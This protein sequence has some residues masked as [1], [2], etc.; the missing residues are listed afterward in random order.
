[1]PRI[2]FLKDVLP[3]GTR[4]S[5]RYIKK[6]VTPEGKKREIVINEMYDAIDDALE[7]DI[8]RHV[9]E[10]RDVY[11]ATAG[12]GKSPKANGDNA[13]AKKEI[14]ID[15]DCGEEKPYATK[16]EGMVALR[17]FVVNVGLPKPTILD[18]G[19]GIHAHWY[20]EAAIPVHEWKSMAERLKTLCIDKNFQVDG[21]C[22]AD[23]VRVL[24]IP[25]T[26]NFRGNHTTKLLTPVK[27]HD[28]SKLAH[29]LGLVKTEN[30]IDFAAARALSQGQP[31]QGMSEIQKLINS[32]RTSKFQTIVNRS[33]ADGTGCAQ[34]KNAI[35]NA[36]SLPEPLWRGVLSIAQYCEDRDWG[37]HHASDAHPNYTPEETEAKAA[38]TK[39]PYT[40]E[41]FQKLDC[42]QLCSG[43][44]HAGKITSPIQLGN[45]VIVAKPEDNKVVA[46]GVEYEIPSYPHPY[47][48]AKSGGIW[49][50]IKDKETGIASQEVIYPYD[51][52]IFK[53]MRDAEHGECNFVRLHLP[54]GDTRE[55]MITQ[56]ELSAV[57]KMRDTISAMG[58]ASFSANTLRYIQEFFALLIVDI[59]QR[60]VPDK[61]KTRM[62]WTTDDTFVVGNREY[63]PQGMQTVPVAKHLEHYAK[64]F[65][66]VG[67]LAEWKKIAAQYKGPESYDYALALLGG[68]ASPLMHFTNENGGIINL[69]S[70]DSGSGKTTTQLVINSIF[71]HPLNL[72]KTEQDTAL[73]KTN[74]MG[75]HNGIPLCFDEMTN[76]K[77]E[78]I[79][80]LVYNSTQGRA[81]DRM[82]ANANAER[83]NDITWKMLTTWSSNTSIEDRLS[84][85]KY[86]PAGELARVIELR[87]AEVSESSNVLAAQQQFGK[88]YDH[89]GVAGH[90]FM[91]Y[92]VPNADV[93]KKIIEDTRADMYSKFA[94]RQADRFRVNILTVIISAGIITNHIGLTDYD[95]AGLQAHA[96]RMITNASLE[97]MQN[98]TKAIETI[99]MY[100]NKNINN[101]LSVKGNVR[102]GG[103]LEQPAREPRGALMVRY[104]TDTKELYI[105]QREFNKWCASVFINSREIPAMFKKE[106]GKDM[107]LVKKRMGKGWDA[108][109]GP[110]LAYKIDDASTT[111]GF[112]DLDTP[113]N[114]PPAATA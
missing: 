44:P 41:S 54:L 96:I 5:M 34:I 27:Y 90:E 73:S 4:Y 87:L 60:E 114:V 7:A 86:N 85:I 46:G 17:D 75:V 101:I 70:K 104:E 72:M 50:Y 108:D 3:D 97:A 103:L 37:I 68:F 113:K 58:V 42:P 100:I 93:V 2:D 105:P 9:N 83:I 109:F 8:E 32:N 94:W 49:R 19:N 63:T 84:T 47:F 107:L 61:M 95:L 18:S 25:D 1:M 39:G 57:D 64:N 59:Q 102:I 26:I 110:V 89:Y 10:G 65:E 31:K 106:T 52:Y 71:G 76:T 111:L 30:V 16:A 82:Q 79:S 35:E 48:R 51:M 66:P 78:D 13:V 23:I 56:R 53:R 20:F 43:C 15:V 24:R 98:S 112:D 45:E 67:S 91:L 81:R 36:A 69:Y 55:F 62:G 6:T 11:Y 28:A 33:V 88:V 77:P 12:F 99:A 40:C 38:L 74:R 22:T 80:T 92:V 21:A 14:Y 29:L